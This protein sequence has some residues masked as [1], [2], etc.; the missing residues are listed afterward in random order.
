M[1]VQIDSREQQ[2]K[3]VIEY[4]DNI[5]QKYIISKLYAGDY[6]NL[7]GPT[8]LIDLKKDIL[9][10]VGNLTK[11]H[12]RFRREILRATEEMNCRFIVLIREQL[13]N[14]EQVKLWQS[15]KNKNG[16]PRTQVKGEILYKIMKTVSEKYKVEWKFCTRKNAGQRIIEILGE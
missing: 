8:I 15:P 9:E 14:L 16:K 7:N 1:I 6:C 11:D 5:N 10:V 3:E 2:N 12:E 4:F 13:E